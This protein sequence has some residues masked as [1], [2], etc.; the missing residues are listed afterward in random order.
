M[1]ENQNS[2]NSNELEANMGEIPADNTRKSAEQGDSNLT[3][4]TNNQN[5]LVNGNADPTTQTL[6]GV[7]RTREENPFSFKHFLKRDNNNPGASAAAAASTTTTSTTNS[8]TTTNNICHSRSSTS[9]LNGDTLT[10]SKSAT[11]SSLNQNQHT[12]ARPK[13]P[14]FQSVH[15]L[16]TGGESKM[17]RSPRFPSFDSQSSLSELSDE[18]SSM[19]HSRSNSSFNSDYPVQRSFSNYDI[20]SPTTESP[21]YDRK[22][23]SIQQ[24]ASPSHPHHNYTGRGSSSE[25]NRSTANRHMGTSEFSAALPDFVQDHLVMEQ[26]YH[27]LSN[28]PKSHS[29]VSVDFE[30]LPDFTINNLADGQNVS[31]NRSNIA[32]VDLSNNLPLDL[33]SSPNHSNNR[34]RSARNPSPIIPLD[35]PRQNNDV[36]REQPPPDL[37]PDIT[38]GQRG[39]FGYGSHS[40]MN[41]D[42]S[43]DKIQTLPDFLSDGPIH[44]SG[45]LAD[46]TQDTPHFNSPDDPLTATISRLQADNDRL[47]NEL[48]DCRQ[49]IVNQTCRISELEHLLIEEQRARQAESNSQASS[50]TESS[51]SS[52]VA[53]LKQQIKQMSGEMQALRRE[54]EALKREEGAVG[55]AGFQRQ[56][57]ISRS[58][59]L[60]RELRLAATT[61]ESNLRQLLSGV[62][63]LR[64]MAANIE[65]MDHLSDTVDDFLSDQDDDDDRFK[66]P[67]L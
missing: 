60:S 32:Y 3:T 19:F 57:G 8:T 43:T 4:T 12:G 2:I 25:A 48:D 17:K 45:R 67:A 58:S 46:V 65:T 1:S 49:I 66:G 22:V 44:S 52:L 54:N 62:E 30:H 36:R 28:S 27:G 51:N 40:D 21:K 10:P 37:P 39:A 59:Q 20:E 5:I 18:R 34:S 29:P 26:W 23:N 35:L 53:K 14:Q 63:N 16:G 6:D 24:N 41:R 31:S 56:R 47:R 15:A 13:I 11:T 61:A 42:Q 33:N 9:I 7:F 55:G 64:L 38:E 50:S